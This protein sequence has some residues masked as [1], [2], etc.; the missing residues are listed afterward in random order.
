MGDFAASGGFIGQSRRGRLE[1][2]CFICLCVGAQLQRAVITLSCKRLRVVCA[3]WRAIP[4]KHAFIFPWENRAVLD[5]QLQESYGE[6]IRDLNEAKTR[7]LNATI[8][9]RKV[10][11]PPLVIKQKVHSVVHKKRDEKELSF[12]P[13]KDGSRKTMKMI[14]FT[15]VRQ[16]SSGRLMQETGEQVDVQTEL[17]MIDL[18]GAAVEL[19]DN[20]HL[21][22]M[23]VYQELKRVYA[24]PNYHWHIWMVWRNRSKSKHRSMK[25]WKRPSNWLLRSLSLMDSKKIL[26]MAWKHIPPKSSSRLTASI[27]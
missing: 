18:F 14:T 17:E 3:R 6:N 11:L 24:M 16:L 26:L 4:P 5:N 19:A 25:S 21:N 8:T 10:N 20:Y 7:S 2:A 15:L 22:P 1:R 13:V 23:T 9:L 27:C 12:A